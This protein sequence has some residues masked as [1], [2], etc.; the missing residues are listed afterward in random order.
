MTT[1]LT[2]SMTEDQNREIT[3]TI[4][5]ERPKLLG[6]IRNRVRTDEDAQDI[7]QDVFYQFVQMYR[8]VEAIQ[9]ASGWLYRVARNRITDLYRKKREVGVEEQFGS[10][11]EER[12]IE[13]LLPLIETIT[14]EDEYTHDIIT[15][16]LEEGL[17]EL[18]PEQREVFVQHEIEGRSFKE[19]SELYGVTVNTLISRKRYAVLHLRKKLSDLFEEIKTG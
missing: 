18:P 16:M 8:N 12:Y 4:N 3:N 6:F 5:R 1:E 15:E 2:Y 7:L 11:D 9:S 19:M 10:R 17:E 14:P 13:E